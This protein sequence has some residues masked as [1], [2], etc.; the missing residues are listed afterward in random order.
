MAQQ[1]QR[2]LNEISVFLNGLLNAAEQLSP[3]QRW[4]RIWQRITA[5]LLSPRCLLSLPS[6]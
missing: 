5:P 3:A 6:G 2:L 1:A 4:E